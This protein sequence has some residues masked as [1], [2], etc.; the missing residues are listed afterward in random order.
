MLEFI[1]SFLYSTIRISTPLIFVGICSTLSSQA[2]LMNMAGESMMLTAALTGVIAS[3]FF[4]NVWLG[5]LCGM[6]SS[7]VVVLI[8]CFAAFVMGVDLYLM[9]ISMNLALTGGTIFVMW[10]IT[11]TK[12]NTAGAINSLA[13]GDVNIPVIENIPILGTILSGHN[14]FTYLAVIMAVLTWILLYKTKLGLRMRAIGQ[15]PGAAESVGI[16]AKKIYTIAFMFAAAIG[17]FG[18]MYLSMGY[19]NFFSRGLTASKGFVGMAAATVGNAEPFLT[20]LMSFIFGAAYA[21]SNYLSTIVSDAYVLM[22]L[23]FLLVTVVYLI[24][25]AYRSGA[26]DRLIKKNQRRLER[27]EKNDLQK[28]DVTNE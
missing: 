5:I 2:G 9:S 21:C 25:S 15:N 19:Q 12:A 20:M 10:A 7:V 6:L 1:S 28:G 22:A 14:V 11:G 18:G 23:P 4:H 13:L 3:A 16:N 24:M 27:L 8:I 26:E 17:S